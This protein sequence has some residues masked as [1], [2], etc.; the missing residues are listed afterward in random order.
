MIVVVYI[1]YVRTWVFS[2]ARK[3]LPSPTDEEIDRI[4]EA[5]DNLD[6]FRKIQDMDSFDLAFDDYFDQNEDLKFNSSV[7]DDVFKSLREKHPSRIVDDRVFSKAGGKNLKQ[8]RKKTSK[9]IVKTNK[10]YIKAGA[11]RVDLQGYDTKVRTEKKAKVKRDLNVAGRIRDK[12]VFSSRETITI[13]NRSVVR[14]RD[15]LGRFVSVRRK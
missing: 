1:H 8:D 2:M 11:S 10:R 13:R 14:Y 12:I 7:R 6:S 15:Q 4:A 5:I 9:R 3:R